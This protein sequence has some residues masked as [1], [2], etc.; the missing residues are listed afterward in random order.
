MVLEV[1]RNAWVDG[2]EAEA[3]SVVGPEGYDVGDWI[4]VWGDVGAPAL[5]EGGP[6]TGE[7]LLG[8]LVG[9]LVAVA[10][11]S[12]ERVGSSRDVHP[13]GPEGSDLLLLADP[14]ASLP[15]CPELSL[16]GSL[17]WG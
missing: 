7:A 1:T 13:H 4:L 10:E 3:G 15:S 17:L 12:D 6:W 9:R 5:G 8:G 2:G 16:V 11:A 14:V